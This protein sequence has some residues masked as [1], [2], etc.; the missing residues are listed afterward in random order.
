MISKTALHAIKAMVALAELPQGAYAG[1]GAIAE[2]IGA[3]RNYLGKLLQNYSHQGFVVSQ[4]GLGGGFQLAKPPKEI[5]L[6]DIVDP[7]DH[8]SRWS[9][10]FLGR[11]SCSEEHPCAVHT[12]WGHVREQYIALLQETTIADLIT[13]H[14]LVECIA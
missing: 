14:K 8:I 10:C 3:P 13:N 2:E 5:T 11:P 12:R 7:I 4:K 6:L 1:A 9:G